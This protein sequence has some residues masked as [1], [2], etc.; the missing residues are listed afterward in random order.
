MPSTLQRLRARWALR[1]CRRVG[2]GVEVRGP[3]YV[4]GGGSVD[5]GDGVILDASENPIELKA[6]PGAVLSLGPGCVI[7]GGVSLEAE[8]KILLGSRVRVRPF[9]KVLDSHFHKLNDINLRPPPGEVSI[10]DGCEV[11]ERSILL[12]GTFLGS[13]VKVGPRSVVSKRV[14]DGAL[15]E[16]NPARIRPQG[17]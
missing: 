4:V 14:P 2:E 1:R 9:A 5:L 3:V 16:G 7:E 17:K 6:G 10:G 15:V 8:N 12:P 11:G 13:G